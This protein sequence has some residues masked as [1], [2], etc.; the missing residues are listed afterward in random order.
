MLVRQPSE[1]ADGLE[2]DGIGLTKTLVLVAVAARHLRDA[3]LVQAVEA[4]GVDAVGRGA[5]GAVEAL[6]RAEEGRG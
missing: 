3:V 5:F 2:S 6:W 1:V 4:L